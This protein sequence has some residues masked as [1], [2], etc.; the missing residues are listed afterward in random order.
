[1]ATGQLPRDIRELETAAAITPQI[2]KIHITLTR[3]YTKAGR[4]TDADRANAVFRALDEARRKGAP[5]TGSPK[6][7][8]E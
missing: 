3:A 7:E 5:A 2:P 6:T 1:M 4:K 8:P